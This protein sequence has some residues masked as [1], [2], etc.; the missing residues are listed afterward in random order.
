MLR[1]GSRPRIPILLF[2]ALAVFIVV[3]AYLVAA[4]LVP[5]RIAE[6]PVSARRQRPPG[7]GPVVVDT[8]TVDARDGGR[9]RFVD[10]TTG[11]VRDHPDSAAWDLAMRRFHVVAQRGAMD[12]GPVP[13]GSVDSVPSGGYVGTR[14]APDTVNA[15][16]ERWYTY[17]FLSHLLQPKLRTFAVPTHDGGYAVLQFLSYYCPGTVA[18]CVTIRYAYRGDGERV[19]R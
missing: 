19:F 2:I 9:W 13:F 1:S 11:Q 7:T 4:P 16:L 12:L 5:Q 18:G 3:L 15:A 10:L 14:W 17:S 6:F 8:V